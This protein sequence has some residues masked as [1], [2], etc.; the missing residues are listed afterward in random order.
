MDS[1]ASQL[2]NKHKDNI[3]LIR[4]FVVDQKL[5]LDEQTK[6]YLD[7]VNK[8]T[9]QIANVLLQTNMT[10]KKKLVTLLGQARERNIK[11]TTTKKR[12]VSQIKESNENVEQLT[13]DDLDFYIHGCPR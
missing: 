6:T 9:I 12:K 8:N 11:N 5:E 3:K 4:D 10:M 13:S 7:L 2:R 1:K